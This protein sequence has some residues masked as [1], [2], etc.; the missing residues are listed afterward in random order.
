[1]S[2]SRKKTNYQEVSDGV[3]LDSEDPYQI[4]SDDAHPELTPKL[5]IRRRLLPNAINRSPTLFQRLTLTH[6]QHEEDEEEGYLGWKVVRLLLGVSCCM[7]I[8]RG[9]QCQDNLTS[10]FNFFLALSLPHS[11]WDILEIVVGS[12]LGTIIGACFALAG[13]SASG[14]PPCTNCTTPNC[15]IPNGTIPN[16]T[17]CTPLDEYMA[18]FFWHTTW[19]VSVSMALL[20]Y[21]LSAIRIEGP[22]DHMQMSSA[23]ISTIVMTVGIQFSYAPLVP[24]LSPESI[25]TPV[26]MN[27][28]TRLLAVFSAAFVSFVFLI[29]TK[30][31]ILLYLKEEIKIV[32]IQG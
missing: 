28:V 16:I 26:L 27:V 31:W 17:G 24:Y 6:L 5:G 12:S 10:A 29:V 13:S 22:G 30:I 23:L 19:T 11:F 7:L 3:A 32:D 1:M 14:W 15:T 20:Y 2:S 4:S 9:M 18:N 21:I 25:W 8:N